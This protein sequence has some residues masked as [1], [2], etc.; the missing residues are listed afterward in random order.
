MRSTR[1][2]LRGGVMGALCWFPR[3]M[4]EIWTFENILYEFI[5]AGSSLLNMILAS[6]IRTWIK[7]DGK[8]LIYHFAWYVDCWYYVDKWS[9]MAKR[10]VIFFRWTWIRLNSLLFN[11]KILSILIYRFLWASKLKSIA[12]LDVWMSEI[13]QFASE[14][15]RAS[16]GGEAEPEWSKSLFHCQQSFVILQ[17]FLARDSEWAQVNFNRVVRG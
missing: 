10:G 1:E 6:Q 8:M 3:R 12:K 17:Q 9:V 5:I 16:P 4:A 2:M 11:L 15:A 7:Q 14:S 13:V